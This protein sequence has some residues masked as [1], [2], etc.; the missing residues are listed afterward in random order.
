MAGKRLQKPARRKK[1]RGMALLISRLIRLGMVAVLLSFLYL[2][3][4]GIRWCANWVSALP[5]PAQSEA[6]QEPDDMSDPQ[7][8]PA[9]P[10]VQF[11]RGIVTVDPGHGGVDPGCG[12]TDALEKDLVLSIST[13]LAQLLEQAGVT[14]VMTRTTDETVSL[15]DR[16]VM[17]NSAASHLFVSI[18]C[19]SYE[20]EARGMDCYYHKNDSAKQ[21]AQAILDRAGEL[22]IVT[23]QVQ[24]NNYQVLWDTDMPAV[25][26]E[27]GFLTDPKDRTA[28]R[29]PAHQ[30]TVARAIADAVLDYLTAQTA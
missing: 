28:L 7:S 2:A 19:N 24:K 21:L 5:A 23:R 10:T 25:L 14:V 15:D 11:I 1:K 13:K 26:V 29:D 6:L 18:H 17:A 4:L 30:D 22:G 20:G 16:A 12:D 3:I 8:P 27:T 9:I